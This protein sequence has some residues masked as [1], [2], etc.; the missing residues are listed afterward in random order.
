MQNARREQLSDF[1][2]HPSHHITAV[3]DP[4]RDWNLTQYLQQANTPTRQDV[5]QQAREGLR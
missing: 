1:E 4:G 5:L 2:R 3:E